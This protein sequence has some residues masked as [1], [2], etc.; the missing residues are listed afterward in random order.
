MQ[1]LFFETDT[2]VRYVLRFLVMLIGFWASWRTGKSMATGWGEI[3]PHVVIYTLL[4]GIGVRFLHHA[5]FAG[6][7]FSA[8]YYI[9][10]TII[11]MIFS[12]LGFRYTRAKQMA[13]NYYWLYEKS[14]PFGWK[15]KSV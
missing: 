13:T 7:M 6:P 15:K 10:D 2:T 11:L 12:V 9:L 1:G 4:L 3:F 5:L 14:G 8:E